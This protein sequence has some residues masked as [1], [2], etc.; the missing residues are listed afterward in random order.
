MDGTIEQLSR[1][2][3]LARQLDPS[4]DAFAD[5]MRQAVEAGQRFL[6]ELDGRPANASVPSEPGPRGT[7]AE[8]GTELSAVLSRL[9]GE[10]FA[11]GINAASGRFM[12]Y[13]PGGG[14]PAAAVGDFLAALTNRYAGVY[15]AGPGAAEIEN[16]C[17]RWLCEL[18]GYGEAAWGTLLSGGT[19]AML[20][21]L[22]VARDSLTP[23][24]WPRAVA[25]STSQTHHAFDKC[26]RVIG[27]G[28][29]HRS[30][31]AIDA[32]HR[33][34]VGDLQDRVAADRAAGR[35]PWLVCAT[36]GT[37]NTGAVDPLEEILSYCRAEGLWGHVDAAYGGCFLLT[38]HGKQLLGGIQDADSVVL[39]PHKGLFLPYGCGAVVVKDGP[40]LRRSFASTADY[41]ADVE[42]LGGTSPADYSPEGTRH[43]RGLR[44]W[45]P[46][47]LHGLTNY[48]ATLD[49]KLLLARYAH[50]Q[51][52]SLPGIEVGPV[53]EL[54]CVVFRTV[55]G[56]AATRELLRRVVH[57]GQ[58]Y[59]SSTRLVGRLYIRLCILNFRTHRKHVEQAVREIAAC[60]KPSP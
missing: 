34:S 27:L 37:T 48:R 55:A 22:T 19:L 7:F 41:L 44:M 49:E 45:L 11:S 51:L 36:A 6:H 59:A 30:Q 9:E 54:S 43:F 47:T 5:W 42:S 20:T 29:I 53:P 13:V 1:L 2:E 35:L 31:V 12:G 56:D 58:V 52:E 50:Q 3:S 38:E 23:S 8:H 17:V 32:G 39:D 40:R 14:I 4:P 60:T 18:V 46:L 21:A 24:T 57:S 15:A 28:N 33:M 26:L 10:V 25:Y 16:Q